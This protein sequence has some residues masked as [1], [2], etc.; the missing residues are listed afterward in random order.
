MLET[1][2]L[3][4]SLYSAVKIMAIIFGCLITIYFILATILK[5]GLKFMGL[6]F[7]PFLLHSIKIFLFLFGGFGVGVLII[8]GIGALL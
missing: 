2:M 5:I 4:V 1:F 8:M 3:A 6:E 7:I